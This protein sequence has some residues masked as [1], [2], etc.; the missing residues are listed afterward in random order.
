MNLRVGITQACTGHRASPLAW[1]LPQGV[2]LP[3]PFLSEQQDD[4]GLGPGARQP[5][6]NSGFSFNAVAQGFI[7]PHH[8]HV[9]GKTPLLENELGVPLRLPPAT[10]LQKGTPSQSPP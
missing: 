8:P 6:S 3:R 4:V 7:H 1:R 2:T 10:L 5:S 9:A